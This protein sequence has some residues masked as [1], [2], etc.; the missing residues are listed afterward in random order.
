[1]VLPTMTVV[2]FLP[3]TFSVVLPHHEVLVSDV[4]Q[5]YPRGLGNTLI[6]RVYPWVTQV[7]MFPW[8]A[9]KQS[10]LFN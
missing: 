2:L 9:E 10:G 6:P 5:W 8:N 7:T 1:M 4:P 3:F